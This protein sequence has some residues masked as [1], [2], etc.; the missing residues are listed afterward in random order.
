[1]DKWDRISSCVYGKP[2][3]TLDESGWKE[4]K[5]GQA[6][7]LGARI[8]KIINLSL[9]SQVAIKTYLSK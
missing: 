1:M 3:A 8:P 6:Q 9:N 4:E 5:M 2:L 7:N